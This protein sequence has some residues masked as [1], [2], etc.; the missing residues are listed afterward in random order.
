M[1]ELCEILSSQ[2]I[3]ISMRYHCSLI[4]LALGIPILIISYDKHAHYPNKMTNIRDLFNADLVNLS[5]FSEIDIGEIVV[6]LQKKKYNIGKNLIKEA[7]AQL[8]NIL[9]NL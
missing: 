4:S 3:I 8:K 9:V 1:K 5:S 7:R 6:N 2:D